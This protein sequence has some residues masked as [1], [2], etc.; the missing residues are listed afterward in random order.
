MLDV[1]QVAHYQC[2]MNK[3]IIFPSNT[4]GVFLI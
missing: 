2:F 3:K 1:V 4:E